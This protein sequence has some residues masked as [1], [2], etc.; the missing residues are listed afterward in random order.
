MRS[1]PTDSGYGGS[2]RR[3]SEESYRRPSE[4][5][6]SY[7]RRPSEDAYGDDGFSRDPFGASRRKASTDIAGRRSG[8]DD[9]DL[10]RRPSGS[11]STTSDSTNATNAQR[12]VIIPN[13][14]IIAEEEI[15]VPY[16]R[17]RE[18]SSTAVGGRASRSP[19]ARDRS[20]DQRDTDG[21]GNLF[22]DND[23]N[24]SRSPR[25]EL[26]GIGGGLGG[27]SGLNGLTARLRERADEDEEGEWSG[28]GRSGNEEYFDK[29][30]LGRVSVASDRSAGGARTSANMNMNT[31]RMSKTGGLEDAESLRR[32]YEYKVAQMQSRISTLERSLEDA[33]ERGRRTRDESAEEKSKVL[34]EEIRFLRDVSLT[35]D[36]LNCYS[37][38][39]RR[40]AIRTQPFASSRASFRLCGRSA[41]MRKIDYFVETR[42]NNRKSSLFEF[43]TSN[44]SLRVRRWTPEY[45]FSRTD[46]AFVTHALSLSLTRK[47]SISFA[48]TWRVSCQSWQTFRI[49]MTNS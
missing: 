1:A 19:V 43:A 47:P 15:E 33:E 40:R 7:R 44:L 27:L 4:D 45:V 9:R 3:P 14:S 24:E 37:R 20:S 32:E 21:E 49:A 8:E 28:T 48:L 29:M 42:N 46:L 41:K 11:I 25:L 31:G 18:S 16:G 26:K 22:A 5:N 38:F 12:E 17:E 10:A 34:E 6:S 30:S 2:V 35:D 39:H 23:P 13:K 36:V